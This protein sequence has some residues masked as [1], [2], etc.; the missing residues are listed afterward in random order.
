[1]FFIIVYFHNES[2]LLQRLISNFK[3]HN[4]E[5]FNF[6]S[7]PT[8]LFSPPLPNLAIISFKHSH[9]QS[10]FHFTPHHS[11]RK[12]KLLVWK[13]VSC[14]DQHVVYLDNNEPLSEIYLKYFH[15]THPTTLTPT[16]TTLLIGSKK[17][18]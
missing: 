8:T 15:Q 3:P 7:C 18:L 10:R 6:T 9:S 4:F 13:Y 16:I 12:T 11:V 17:T 14:K 5:L 1:M 2:H